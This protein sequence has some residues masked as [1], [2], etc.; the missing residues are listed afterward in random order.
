[1]GNFRMD[2]INKMY[3][4]LYLLSKMMIALPIFNLFPKIKAKSVM[5]K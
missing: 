4:I 1:M 2:K 5:N 3:A